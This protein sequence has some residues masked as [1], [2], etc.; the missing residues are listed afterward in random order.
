[1][2]PVTFNENDPAQVSLYDELPLIGLSYWRRMDL[3]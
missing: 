1:M 2:K 3:K